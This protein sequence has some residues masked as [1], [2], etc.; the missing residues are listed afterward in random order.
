MNAMEQIVCEETVKT[1]NGHFDENY[2]EAAVTLRDEAYLRSFAE[3]PKSS[4]ALQYA[5]GFRY[6]MLEKPVTVHPYDIF[7]GCIQYVNTSSSVP[8]LMPRAF[9]PA[10]PAGVFPDIEREVRGYRDYRE[11]SYTNSEEET[12]S[13]FIKSVKCG[14]GKRWPNGH[15]IPGF[16]FVL[17]RGFK[18]LAGEITKNGKSAREDR[19]EFFD[20]MKIC[21]ETASLYA[22]RCADA[23]KRALES[24]ENPIW[25]KNL[26]RIA[27]SC[28]R[29]AKGA[30]ENF[31]DA[32]QC[33]ILMQ[34]MILSEQYSGSLSLGRVDQLFYPYYVKDS[35]DGKVRAEEAQ[36]LIDALWLKLAGL[37]SG[38]QNA[39]V[40]GIDKDGNS[41][42]NDLTLFCLRSSRKLK[43]DQ[44]LLSL[45][46]HKG[47]SEACWNEA[48]ALIVQGGGFPA[49]FNDRTVMAARER[50]GVDKKDSWNYAMVGCVEPS[51]GGDE[52]SFTEELR[53]NWAKVIE[54]MLSGGIC[55]V[56][57]I[58]MGLTCVRSLDDIE[59][60]ETFY[61]WYK[62][63]FTAAFI[64]CI[65]AVKLLDVS[66]PV[67]FPSP[68]LSSTMK[69]CTEKGEDASAKGP[70]YCFSTANS[71]G[72]A[73]A[74]DS[75]MA[76]KEMVFNRKMV[77]LSDFAKACA[78]DF[79]GY[80]EL[81]AC[82]QNRCPK[83]GNDDPEVDCYMKD[84]TDLFCT[85]AHSQENSRGGRFQAGLYTVSDQALM[86]RL[87]G[88]LPDGREKGVSLA[89]AIAAVQ[90]K[91]TNGP[92]AAV[93]SALSFDHR[94]AA[95]GLVLDLKF[96]P[97]FFDKEAHRKALRSLIESYFEQGGLE[98]QFNVVS[99]E[100]LL[101]AQ[102]K[103]QEYH[104]L[105]VRVS[106]FSAYFTQLDK[107]VQ[108][109]IINRTEHRSV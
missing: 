69:G 59:D 82:A 27:A 99:R 33:F 11:D 48:I 30:P 64:K 80:G 6:F 52:F 78:G 92:T 21:A 43:K 7:A 42:V 66:Y 13:W 34:D 23:A 91:D 54:L 74:V 108:D 2:E 58:D 86:G 8:L 55:T 26:N 107:A 41:A 44:P 101:A 106:G 22:S 105:V 37:V 85:I 25:K 9:H 87:T 90:G 14:L 39:T 49:M 36:L 28:G 12:L 70:K 50:Q 76:I 104:S 15:V 24:A 1:L 57:G 32:I 103:P 77:S 79:E 73:N 20:A 67:N 47:M 89:N 51:I 29:I 18:G 84:L 109:E 3:N 96:N 88:A 81:K 98:V 95:N 16:D 102:S 97:S 65:N 61:E 71:L 4:K 10:H 83:Y 60:F 5:L 45:R 19:K 40:G 31:F 72:M 35:A 63:E 75:L 53:F 68:F 38:F 17:K 46:T 62:T 94:N 56:T 100:T 93:R